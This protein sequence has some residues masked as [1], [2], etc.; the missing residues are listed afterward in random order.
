MQGLHTVKEGSC[1]CFVYLDDNHTS[2]VGMREILSDKGASIFCASK[3]A[4]LSSDVR[5]CV[6]GR[7]GHALFAYPAQSNFS[8]ERYP[9]T[10]VQEIQSESDSG[11][12]GDCGP[13]RRFVL[14]DAAGYVCT[15]Q[16]D[17]RTLRPDFVP[18]SFYKMFGFPTGVGESEIFR[19]ETGSENRRINDGVVFE[20]SGRESEPPNSTL[21]ALGSC[22]GFALHRFEILQA[23]KTNIGRVNAYLRDC[24]ENNSIAMKTIRSSPNCLHHRDCFVR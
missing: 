19:R 20:T 10:W 24:H 23:D 13:Q 1:G 3:E 12:S 9:L 14:L 15:S 4:F 6:N 7:S 8:G 22:V 16:L 18:V 11:G 2:L 21:T 17:L 5:S